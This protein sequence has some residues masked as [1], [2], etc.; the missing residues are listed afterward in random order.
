MGGAAGGPAGGG[1]ALV[2]RQAGGGHPGEVVAQRH[3]RSLVRHPPRRDRGHLGSPGLRGA[4]ALTG[5]RGAARRFLWLRYVALR[6]VVD[7]YG[8][9][10]LVAVVRP[11]TVRVVHVVRP[12]LPV[13]RVR[14]VRT[15]GAVRLVLP[16]LPVR[17][18]PPV[19]IGCLDRSGPRLGARSASGV[20]GAVASTALRMNHGA[21]HATSRGCR[22]GM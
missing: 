8:V 16:V 11:R 10:V 6:R 21:P 1:A 2:R 22:A 5:V 12:V 3:E 7:R 9:A 18:V 19:R 14:P 15:V 4:R 20:R 13:R 17:R